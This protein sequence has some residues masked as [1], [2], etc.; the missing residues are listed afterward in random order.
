MGNRRGLL[1]FSA[2]LVFFFALVSISVA[3]APNASNDQDLKGSG[4]DV[5]TDEL[6]ELLG[7]QRSVRL[8]PS[9]K[10]LADWDSRLE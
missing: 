1:V 6:I 10:I 3:E 5:T 9:S 7:F 2:V 8:D 4:F